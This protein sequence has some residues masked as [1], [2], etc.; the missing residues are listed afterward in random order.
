MEKDTPHQHPNGTRS[1]T[2]TNGVVQALSIGD[3]SIAD[4]EFGSLEGSMFAPWI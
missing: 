3:D 4:T 1:K 2:Q